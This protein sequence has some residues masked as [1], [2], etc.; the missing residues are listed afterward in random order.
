MNI[1]PITGSKPADDVVADLRALADLAENDPFV[2]AMI[3][4]YFDKAIWPNHVVGY[5]HDSQP[6]EVMAEA[7]RRLKPIA[8]EPVRKVYADHGE[9]YLKVFVPLKALT[10]ELTEV[11]AQ[12]CERVVTGV[13]T[14]T[15]EIPDP[16]YLAAAPKITR[17]REVETV[18]W[19]CVP[20]LAQADEAE[21]R[22]SA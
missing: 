5:E 14:V 8:A 18:E 13:E 1:R 7:I 21:T 3:A 9:G 19:K 10:L 6:K 4:R 20:L 12:V 15:E 11:R 2:A 16:E 17:T 22:V